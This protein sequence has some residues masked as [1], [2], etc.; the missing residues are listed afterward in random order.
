MCSMKG[1]LILL[2]VRTIREAAAWFKQEDPYTALTETAIRGLIYK[3]KIPYAKVGKKYLITI[4]A[5]EKYLA[6]QD[7]CELNQ[8]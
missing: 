2:R 8:K 7:N 6:G 4:E 3:N 5:L 1:V